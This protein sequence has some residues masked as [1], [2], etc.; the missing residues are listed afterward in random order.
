[1]KLLL[2]EA[3]PTVLVIEQPRM[4]TAAGLRSELSRDSRYAQTILVTIRDR[5]AKPSCLGMVRRI[6]L[7]GRP[8]SGH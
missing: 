3:T 4:M 5:L 2:D 1:M 6:T 7:Q 8:T